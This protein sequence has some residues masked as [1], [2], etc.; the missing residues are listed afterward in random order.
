MRT[1]ATADV[2]AENDLVVTGTGFA[3]QGMS[4]RRSTRLGTPSLAAAFLC[5]ALA[6]A[7]A[8]EPRSSLRCGEV[9][10]QCLD[11]PGSTV[12]ACNDEVDACN[13]TIA[14]ERRRSQARQEGFEDFKRHRDAGGADRNGNGP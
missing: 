13:E 11:V 1:F 8:S 5:A 2:A 6:A 9:M 7:C 10:R 3:P 14:D 4:T 12:L